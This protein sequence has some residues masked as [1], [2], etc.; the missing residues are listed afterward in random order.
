MRSIFSRAAALAGAIAVMSI[1]LATT[2]SAAPAKL[3]AT[4]F[5]SGGSSLSKP[6]DITAMHG[7]IFVAWQNGVGP[8]GEPA[9]NGATQSTIVRYSRSGA[10]LGQWNLTG[11]VDG[12]TADPQDDRII[13]TV[14]ED[15]NS[16]LFVID[17]KRSRLVQYTYTGLTHGGG[18]DAPSVYRDQLFVS[19]SNPSDST[20]PAVYR[21]TLSGTT[22]SLSPVFFDN[23]TAT[24]A[25]P[26]G[27]TQTL[28]LTDPDSNTV[29]P[30]SSPRFGHDFMLDSQGDGQLIFAHD[31]GASGQQLFVLNLSPDAGT[32]NNTV[33]V[34]DTAWATSDRGTL[35]ATDGSHLIYAVSGH[36]DVGT[37]LTSVT[38][39]NANN[40]PATPGPNFLATIDLR[41]G[42]LTPVAGVG[43]HPKGLVFVRGA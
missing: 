39:G 9:A 5:A 41:D 32:P 17:V 36:F 21:V 24:I 10:V 2:A 20:Q 29:V 7:S 31:A 15:G 25:N 3:T 1:G 11:R 18:T 6:D 27:G 38:P 13:A 4:V 43:F 37:A 28:G 14:N 34:D 26:G 22:A 42:H 35:Y 23:S 12:M 16:S 8:M 40:A 33:S 19:A 30:G